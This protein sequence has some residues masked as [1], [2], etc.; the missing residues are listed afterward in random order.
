MEEVVLENAEKFDTEEMMDDLQQSVDSTLSEG[1]GDDVFSEY[2]DDLDYDKSRGVYH[3]VYEGIALEEI[4]KNKQVN[5]DRIK[6]KSVPVAPNKGMPSPVVFDEL[7]EI[8]GFTIAVNDKLMVLNC[9]YKDVYGKLNVIC[10]SS[11]F[12]MAQVGRGMTSGEAASQFPTAASGTISRDISGYKSDIF[13]F[14]MRYDD[15]IKEGLD[16]ADVE[17]DIEK[18]RVF[19]INFEPNPPIKYIHFKL[20]VF[21]VSS[22]T[23]KYVHYFEIR[24][25]VYRD[26]TNIN[27]DSDIADI[28]SGE[29]LTDQ[30]TSYVK[31]EQEMRADA[32][33]EGDLLST[34]HP[35]GD[36][37]TQEAGTGDDIINLHEAPI[38]PNTGEVAAEVY[39]TNSNRG[40]RR[41]RGPA[42]LEF[43]S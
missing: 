32:I 22:T 4:F 1:G 34:V 42:R 2:K 17:G 38:N 11:A 12:E 6:F 18:D 7:G 35:Q 8:T 41:R 21:N 13:P 33:L 25:R 14:L 20:D 26:L 24:R 31:G 30:P 27:V 5:D 36:V 23:T 10:D 43:L 19:V 3:R 15:S 37:F 29:T 39:F 40:R 28:I 16:E 9:E